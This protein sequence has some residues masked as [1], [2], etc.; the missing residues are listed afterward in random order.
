VFRDLEARPRQTEQMTAKKIP[1]K[2][3][4][5]AIWPPLAKIWGA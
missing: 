1:T 4:P 5:A 2:P 3:P